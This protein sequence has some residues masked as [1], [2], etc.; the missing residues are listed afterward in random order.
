LKLRNKILIESKIITLLVLI[1][2]FTSLAYADH[3][4]RKMCF[5]DC[6]RYAEDV[7][8]S[9]EG[10]EGN[11]FYISDETQIIKGVITVND[12][13]PSDGDFH[14]MAIHLSSGKTMFDSKMILRS[15]ADHHIAPFTILLN[16]VHTPVGEYKIFIFSEHKEYESFSFFILHPEMEIEEEE[17]PKVPLW[18]KE[19]AGWYATDAINEDEF[20]SA[21]EYLIKNNIINI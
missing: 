11:I 8:I 16:G 12:Y 19:I 14:L 9:L 5:E 13:T 10:V 1:L 15:S 20:L 17:K 18:V 3:D 2:G 4:N 6:P 21:I 7:Y